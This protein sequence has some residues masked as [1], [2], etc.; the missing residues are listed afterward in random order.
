MY[1]L[2]ILPYLFQDLEPYID[3]HTMGLHYHKHEQNYL[4]KLNELLDKNNFDYRYDI[5]ELFYHIDEFNES[6]RVDILYNLGGVLNHNLYW[7]S[8]SPN[9][10]LP[11]GKLKE[12]IDKKYGSID[13]FFLEFKNKA[14]SLKGSGYT[15]LVV[16]DNGDLDIINLSN[17]ELPQ[18]FGFIPL[19]NM[20]M[21]E[22]AYYLNYKN[23]KGNYIDN[24]L[25]IADFTNANNLYNSLMK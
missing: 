18:S 13:K 12:D 14:M 16:K 17:Q 4:N 23:E 24:F 21:W 15:F 1:K 19:F 11:S 22:H 3:T 5:D 8:M 25:M 10:V 2:P 6:D 20:D 9:R 7:K